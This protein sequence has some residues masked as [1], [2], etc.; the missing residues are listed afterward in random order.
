[1]AAETKSVPGDLNNHHKNHMLYTQCMMPAL[2]EIYENH[3]NWSSLRSLEYWVNWPTGVASTKMTF[4]SKGRTIKSSWM[5]RPL[6]IHRLSPLTI[7]VHN[8]LCYLYCLLKSSPYLC[9]PSHI[10]LN[11]KIQPLIS[12][13]GNQEC[14]TTRQLHKSHLV[15]YK[16]HIVLMQMLKLAK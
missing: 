15:L 10:E 6:T 13:D 12:I 7:D 3:D 5:S 14:H 8:H 16:W 11:S 4:A 2:K 9:L 1:M